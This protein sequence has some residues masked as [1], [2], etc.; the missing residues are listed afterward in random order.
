MEMKLSSSRKSVEKDIRG[1]LGA[2]VASNSGTISGDTMV[3]FG[4][5][6]WWVMGM[7]WKEVKV[8]LFMFWV[9]NGGGGDLELLLV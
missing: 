8:S 1:L 6:G 9:Y 2:I 5:L 7:L 4:V 3:V